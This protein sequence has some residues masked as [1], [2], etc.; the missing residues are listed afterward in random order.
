MDEVQRAACCCC[1]DTANEIKKNDN[2]KMH[3][4]RNMMNIQFQDKIKVYDLLPC[5]LF[6]C[7]GITHMSIIFPAS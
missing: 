3:F 5:V 6:G 7:V 1:F 4:H 2:Y